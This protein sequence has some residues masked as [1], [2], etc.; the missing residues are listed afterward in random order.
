MTSLV[1]RLVIGRA[2][3][4]GDQHGDLAGTSTGTAFGESLTGAA[5]TLAVG[6]A[7]STGEAGRA[8]GVAVS[9]GAVASGAAGLQPAK[10]SDARIETTR[11]ITCGY[12]MQSRPASR[13]ES[14]YS[15]GQSGDGAR[16]MGNRA[17]LHEYTMQTRANVSSPARS[18]P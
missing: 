17:L 18:E 10:T 7:L 15:S 14:V 12:S 8:V 13:G 16:F 2:V 4:G 11:F 1:E 3:L 5:D 6:A 9:V